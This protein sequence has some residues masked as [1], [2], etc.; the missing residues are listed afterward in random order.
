MI[1][2]L[3]IILIINAIMKKKKSDNKD[4]DKNCSSSGTDND[5]ESESEQEKYD[6]PADYAFP[7]FVAYVLWHPF[8]NE[9]DKLP[10]FSLD[11]ADKATD[12]SRAQ[13]RK[14]TLK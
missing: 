3:L 10:L 1:L 5:E 7:S 13:R 9:S 2:T 11:H 12:M 8:S 14:A 6:I 4:I